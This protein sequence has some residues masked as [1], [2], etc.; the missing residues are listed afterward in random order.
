MSDIVYV[1]RYSAIGG[2]PDPATV[3]TG[4]CEGMGTYPVHISDPQLTDY[5]RAAMAKCEPQ[6]DGWYF[7]T[8][9]ACGGTGKKKSH[10]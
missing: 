3:C 5:E 10:D 8:C 2:H 9:G 7:I 1:D 4:Q 6:A